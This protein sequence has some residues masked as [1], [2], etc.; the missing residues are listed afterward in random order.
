MTMY[1]YV[2][3]VRSATHVSILNVLLTD[4]ATYVSILNVL[5]T[6]ICLLKK[7]TLTL[8]KT[9]RVDSIKPYPIKRR[10]ITNL[11]LWYKTII[12]NNNL[13]HNI[14][15]NSTLEKGRR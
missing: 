15:M 6:D 9:L 1:L 14:S 10:G 7:Q 3:S 5:L 13:E 4:S 8:W 12:A 11:V 2:T